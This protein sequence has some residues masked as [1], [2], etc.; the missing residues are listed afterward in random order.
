MITKQVLYRFLTLI[1]IAVMAAGASAQRLNPYTHG[2]VAAGGYKF[3][4]RTPDG[5]NHKA[6]ASKGWPL[7]IFLHG[8]SLCGNNLNSVLRYGTLDAIS[9]G[10]DI[11]AVVIAPQNPGGAWKPAKLNDILDWATSNCNIDPDRVYVLGMSLGGYGTLDFAGT[12]PDRIAA[13][14]ALCGGCTL[15]NQE[16]L[17]ELPLW[18]IHGTADRAISISQSR[19]VVNGLVNQGKQDR[20]R[21]DWLKGASHSALARIFYMRETYDWLLSHSLSDKDRPLNRSI[22]ITQTAMSTVYR[23]LDTSKRRRRR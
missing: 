12:Y 10:R 5:Y 17:S 18:I 22:A 21:F 13:A 7:I 19:S 6:G 20:L 11:P 2:A 15:K 9:M 3:W 16:R 14:M 23:G 8:S 1:I 4:V